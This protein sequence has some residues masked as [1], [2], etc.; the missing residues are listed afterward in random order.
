MNKINELIKETK[1]KYHPEKYFSFFWGFISALI[2]IVLGNYLSSRYFPTPYVNPVILPIVLLIFSGTVGLY[3]AEFWKGTEDSI[4]MS[5]GFL[6]V[7][8]VAMVFL[9]YTNSIT[10]YM[11]LLGFLFGLTFVLSGHVNDTE[12]IISLFHKLLKKFSWYIFGFDLT[13]SYEIP[14]FQKVLNIRNFAL[15]VFVGILY[16]VFVIIVFYYVDK[17]S[18]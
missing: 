6:I 5:F 8:F 12:K 16:I 14:L 9:F 17:K 11:L 18:T 4:A 7:L 2:L 1:S 15:M 3:F 10:T 13:A